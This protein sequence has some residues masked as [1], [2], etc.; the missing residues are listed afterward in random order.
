MRGE[1]L[2]VLLQP[3]SRPEDRP[4]P[5]EAREN[6]SCQ[7]HSEARDGRDHDRLHRTRRDE[8]GSDADGADGRVL[9]YPRSCHGDNVF[10]H[11]DEDLNSD[12][13]DDDFL[14]SARMLV[15][16]LVR[17]KAQQLSHDIDAA[18]QKLDARAELEVLVNEPVEGI[19]VWI[20]PAHVGSVKNVS[21]QVD[22]VAVEDEA[23]VGAGNVPLTLADNVALGCQLC[24]KASCVFDGLL[25]RLCERGEPGRLSEAVGS[26][27]LLENRSL[28]IFGPFAG[29]CGQDQLVLAENV[30][31]TLPIGVGEVIFFR[32]YVSLYLTE[33]QHSEQLELLLLVQPPAHHNAIRKYERVPLPFVR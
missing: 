19:Q 9:L 33:P 18:V 30:I 2:D 31:E 16:Q 22:S 4:P 25:H 8:R 29:P 13:E 15:L 27:Q 23:T 14:Q 1:S 26:C 10:D 12:E 20:L 21:V 32:L 17:E 5:V 24:C 3:V 6:S 11:F 28:E 7:Q